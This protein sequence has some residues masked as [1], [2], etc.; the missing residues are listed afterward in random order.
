MTSMGTQKRRSRITGINRQKQ[1]FTNSIGEVFKVDETAYYYQINMDGVPILDRWII[2]N[3][4]YCGHIVSD[5]CS[6]VGKT[7]SSALLCLNNYY[8]KYGYPEE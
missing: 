1:I 5:Q 3:I 7:P 2:D 4:E 8:K 6:E